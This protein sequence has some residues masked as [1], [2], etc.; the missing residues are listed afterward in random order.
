MNI[1]TKAELEELENNL[2]QA[3]HNLEDLKDSFDKDEICKTTFDQQKII[4]KTDMEETQKAIDI[5]EE[6]EY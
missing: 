4:F 3:Q 1:E 6:L 2:I 5:L